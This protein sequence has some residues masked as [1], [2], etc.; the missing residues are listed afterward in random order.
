[1]RAQ[2]K[3]FQHHLSVLVCSLLLTVLPLVEIE[4]ACHFQGY[5]PLCTMPSLRHGT[6]HHAALST[7][8]CVYYLRR[9]L[10]VHTF[11]PSFLLSTISTPSF[12]SN[13]YHYFYHHFFFYYIGL[14]LLLLLENVLHQQLFICVKFRHI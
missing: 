6:S 4:K 9:F 12:N 11:P 10:T 2:S 5:P 8:W 1:M 14:F 3:F 7:M 13:N